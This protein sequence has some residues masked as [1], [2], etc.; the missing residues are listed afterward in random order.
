MSARPQIVNNNE[1]IDI[2]I[3]NNKYIDMDI[4]R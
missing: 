2:N 3:N 4:D 1:N